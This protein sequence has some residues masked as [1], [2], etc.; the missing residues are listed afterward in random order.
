MAFER[1]AGM[2]HRG[3]LTRTLIYSAV[4]FATEVAFSA[5]H[6]R[7]RGEKV[8][9]RTSVWMF[10]IYALITPLYE[11]LHRVL[12]GNTAV[13]RAAIY[14]AGF[15][16][17]E[18][19]TGSLLRSA[20]GE[21]PWDYS[22]ARVHVNGLIRLDYFFIWAVAGLALE[23]LHDGLTTQGGLSDAPDHGQLRS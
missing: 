7:K 15:L 1:V 18:Y 9:L 16:A 14:G 5:I 10:P 11:P 20:H 13:Q 12:E 17:T 19:A 2:K 6:D 3:P 8:R 21:A 22:Y 4:G 23:R